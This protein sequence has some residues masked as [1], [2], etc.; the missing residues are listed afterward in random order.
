MT[1]AVRVFALS[2]LALMAIEAA[3]EPRFPRNNGP[4]S[5]RRPHLVSPQTV[6]GTGLAPTT[7]GFASHYSGTLY[8]TGY[9]AFK[10]NATFSGINSMYGYTYN[11]PTF[12]FVNEI[13]AIY[14]FDVAGLDGQ[15]SPV[16]S[17]F[18][19]DTRERP[20]PGNDG[21]SS[22]A[23]IQLTS[24]GGN[25]HLT[26]SLLFIGNNGTNLDIYDAEDFENAAPFDHPELAFSGAN[27]TLIGTFPIV[28]D[29][30]FP[31]DFDVTDAV[32]GDLGIA[33]PTGPPVVE[34]PV[35]G[36]PGILAL[37]LLLAGA[38][39]FLLRR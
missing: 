32:N 12:G 21:I 15:P 36:T 4:V 27:N 16:W 8:G 39:A 17:A 2:A 35:L 31:L 13:R 10:V 6:T 33:G 5:G 9:Y 37:A 26:G 25:H 1:K 28:T 14:A 19:F 34:V 23:A 22:F 11:Y 18:M 29:Q 38:G 20:D 30:I 24:T 3:A 7:W